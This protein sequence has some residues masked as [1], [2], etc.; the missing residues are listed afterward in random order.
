MWA[1]PL[2]VRKRAELAPSGVFGRVPG[3]LRIVESPVS[4]RRILPNLYNFEG[5]SDGIAPY[6]TLIAD[7]NGILYGSTVGGGSANAGVV[8]SLTRPAAGQKEWAEAV[9]YPFQGNPDGVS[10]TNGL[11]RDDTGAIYGMTSAGGANSA[12][13]VYRLTAPANG[14]GAWSE[15]ILYNFAGAP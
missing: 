12:G 13:T 10:P 2:C 5:G 4:R 14:G 3:M 1:D 8:F 11:V 6:G 9:L 7:G 15:T